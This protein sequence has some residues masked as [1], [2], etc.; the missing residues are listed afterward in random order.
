MGGHFYVGVWKKGVVKSPAVWKRDDELKSTN[1]FTGTTLFPE[2]NI[3]CMWDG[4]STLR[5]SRGHYCLWHR[6]HCKFA[7]NTSTTMGGS[8]LLI[9]GICHPV[10]STIFYQ[11][12]GMD[13]AN[14]QCEMGD[15]VFL[16]ISLWIFLLPTI[17]CR[18]LV[19]PQ[20]GASSQI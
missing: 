13:D 8:I 10:I 3:V 4:G 16:L 5:V 15:A 14:H 6:N 11:Y 12:G 9:M 7:I 19:G 20:M 17:Y 18:G 2:K 1:G